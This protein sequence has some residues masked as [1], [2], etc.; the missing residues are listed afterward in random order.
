VDISFTVCL[1]VCLFVCVVCLFVRLRISP[2]RI[3]LAASHFARWLIGVQG[4]EEIFV[5]FA[6]PKPQI[7][8]IS[9]RAGQTHR[10]VNITAEML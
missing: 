1:F 2:P 4:R 6:P 5:N 9:Q 10:D 8:R 7:G 3:K